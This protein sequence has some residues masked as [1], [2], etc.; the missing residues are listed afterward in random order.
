[1]ERYLFADDVDA[2]PG[3][4]GE[5]MGAEFHCHHGGSL[6]N[7]RVVSLEPGVESTLVFD[8]PTTMHITTRLTDEEEGKT[9]ITRSFLWEEP[10]DAEVRDGLKQMMQAMVAAGEGAISEVLEA[11]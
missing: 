8:Q 4:H 3:A 5:D 6:V 7:M 9:K 11:S 1:M 2:I 10:P